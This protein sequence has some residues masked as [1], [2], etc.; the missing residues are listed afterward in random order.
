SYIHVLIRT[1]RT[2]KIKVMRSIKMSY[3]EF[4]TLSNK[5]D[6]G[7]YHLSGSSYVPNSYEGCDNN[8][9]FIGVLATCNRVDITDMK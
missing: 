4:W 7:G 6:I 3:Q 2:H 5:F 9:E 8:G 1:G